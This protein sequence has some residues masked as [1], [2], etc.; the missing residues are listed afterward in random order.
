MK[1]KVKLLNTRKMMNGN[2]QP[3]L[4]NLK[5]NVTE[6]CYFETCHDISKDANKQ[7]SAA[8]LKCNNTH[9]SVVKEIL[10]LPSTRPYSNF[11][12]CRQRSKGLQVLLHVTHVKSRDREP[13]RIFIRKLVDLMS[14]YRTQRHML[15]RFI[16]QSIPKSSCFHN[17]L[18][19][20]YRK[21]IIQQQTYAYIWKFKK[22]FYAKSN[23]RIQR[24]AINEQLTMHNLRSLKNIIKYASRTRK[25]KVVITSKCNIQRIRTL[26]RYFLLV[27]SSIERPVLAHC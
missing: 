9:A 24:F 14:K 6:T 23:N 20:S 1:C 10:P 2:T 17:L 21:G 12:Q 5:S 22:L 25:Q 19:T 26:D 7:N 4:G 8:S 11:S 27:C 16:K 13:S 15:K 18:S 3:D